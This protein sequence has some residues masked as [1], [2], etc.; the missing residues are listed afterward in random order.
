MFPCQRVFDYM[1]VRW[2]GWSRVLMTQQNFRGKHFCLQCAI[3][4]KWRSFEMW[5]CFRERET[6]VLLN[7]RKINGL[8][9]WHLLLLTQLR[10]AVNGEP[11]CDARL[12]KNSRPKSC[13]GQNRKQIILVSWNWQYLKFMYVNVCKWSMFWQDYIYIFLKSSQ[14]RENGK[15]IF[16][17]LQTFKKLQQFY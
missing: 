14:R 12:D 7:V 6:K 4:V 13:D 9:C 15:G 5:N 2:L 17:L 3:K 1:L 8:L 16:S 11:S 10:F